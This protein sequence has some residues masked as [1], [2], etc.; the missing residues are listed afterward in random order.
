MH[1]IL[2]RLGP[3]SPRTSPPRES[4]QAN[5][6]GPSTKKAQSEPDQEA[7]KKNQAASKPATVDSRAE[8]KQP[9]ERESTASI[10][11]RRRAA[12]AARGAAA[13]GGSL[14]AYP[15]QRFAA[16]ASGN[17]AAT[18]A[19][20]NSGGDTKTPAT[21]SEPKEAVEEAAPG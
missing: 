5:K 3:S 21:E 2:E 1:S 19:V 12:R 15:G 14:L 9:R 4:E 10:L 18:V 17:D 20:R 6:G 16:K 13:A 8:A 7:L 11:E